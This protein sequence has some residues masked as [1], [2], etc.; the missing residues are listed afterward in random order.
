[1]QKKS[2]SYKTA[3]IKKDKVIFMDDYKDLRIMDE[4]I[5]GN[6][7]LCF[8]ERH[9][10][11]LQKNLL[12]NED[13]F[14]TADRLKLRYAGKKKAENAIWEFIYSAFSNHQLEDSDEVKKVCEC[15]FSIAELK[16]YHIALA[17]GIEMLHHTLN[18]WTDTAILDAAIQN[19][20]KD[21]DDNIYWFDPVSITG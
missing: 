20:G 14:W 10:L 9:H 21:E 18:Y 16:D 3:L 2:G 5:T 8:L 11:R 17:S 7:P 12:M 1:M 15:L 4:L 13:E 6:L 19:F